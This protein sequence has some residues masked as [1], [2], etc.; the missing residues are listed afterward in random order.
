MC[1]ACKMHDSDEKC[2]QTLVEILK[3]RD[4]LEGIGIDGG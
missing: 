2:V 3:D 4:Q 1:R